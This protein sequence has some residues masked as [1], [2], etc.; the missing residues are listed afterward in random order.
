MALFNVVP[1]SSSVEAERLDAEYFDQ[2]DL[3]TVRRLREQGGTALGVLCDVLTGTT[4]KEYVA[5]A[6]C[7]VVR[8]GD[9][10]AP[11]IYPACGRPFLRTPRFPKAVELRQGDVL[12]SSIGMGSIGKISLVMD[13]QNFITVSE[14]TILRHLSV[15]PECVFAYLRTSVGQ[16]LIAREV[17]GATGQQHLLPRNA[18]RV[19]VPQFP[20]RLRT[21]LRTLCQRAWDSD[22]RAGRDLRRLATVEA[23]GI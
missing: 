14:V 2:N 15:P 9:L 12:I 20:A 22:K 19:V 18:S 4:P 6:E 7:V 16:R 3:D 1:L 10:V 5:E 13:A 21:R 23:A 11:F 17:T 8:S